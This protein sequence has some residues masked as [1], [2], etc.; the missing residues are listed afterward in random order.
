MKKINSIWYG[1]AILKSGLLF[2]FVIPL[3]LSIISKVTG[4]MEYLSLPIELSAVIGV[5]ILI[6][7]AALLIIELKQDKRI[8]GFYA[9]NKNTKVKLSNGYYECQNCGSQ[10]LKEDNIVCPVCGTKLKP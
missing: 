7:L 2:T 8:N 9:A 4:S 3:L 1:A 10:K 6:F 5:L